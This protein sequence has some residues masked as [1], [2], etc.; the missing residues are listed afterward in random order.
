MHVFIATKEGIASD[1]CKVIGVFSDSEIAKS[2]INETYI[3]FPSK[4][5][6]VL[7]ENSGG[8]FWLFYLP[9]DGVVFIIRSVM[10]DDAIEGLDN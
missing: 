10:L 5:M 7:D 9:S 2:Y 3:Q 8:H 4:Q 6:W 1:Y